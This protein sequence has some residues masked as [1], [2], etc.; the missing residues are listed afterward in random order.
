VPARTDTRFF[1][2]HIYRKPGVSV[3]FIK[4]RLRF[5]SSTNSAPFPSMLVVFHGPQM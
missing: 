3:E 5:G 1:H 2:E 4:G